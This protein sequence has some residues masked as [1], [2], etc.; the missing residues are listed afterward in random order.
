VGTEFGV[1][2]DGQEFLSSGG[3]N[4]SH[5]VWNLSDLFLLFIRGQEFLGMSEMLLWFP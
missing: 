3:K 2:E 5:V 4:L 1:S